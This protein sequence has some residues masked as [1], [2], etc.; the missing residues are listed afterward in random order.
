MTILNGHIHQVIQKVEGNVTYHTAYSTA[1]PQPSPGV[2]PG[3][4]PLQ[5]PADKLKTLL[6]IRQ[7]DVVADRVALTDTTLA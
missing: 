6:G 7:L 3:P 4:G 2:G 5:V 1:F